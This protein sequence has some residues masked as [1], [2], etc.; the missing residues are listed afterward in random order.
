MAKASGFRNPER[1]KNTLRHDPAKRS[2]RKRRSAG[3]TAARALDRDARCGR[4]DDDRKRSC[5]LHEPMAS[6]LR[7][8]CH[9]AS[10]GSQMTDEVARRVL[11]DA[12]TESSTRP[13]HLIRP[14]GPPSPQRGRHDGAMSS[15][16]SLHAL[17]GS[18]GEG[19]FAVCFSVRYPDLP[20]ISRWFR[21]TRGGAPRPRP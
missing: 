21:S 6:P 8:S 5:S 19:S 18:L 3:A 9:L 12:A 13:V 2:W 16:L 15:I 17:T 11:H 20:R 14:C 1:G 10:H 7:G 4:R